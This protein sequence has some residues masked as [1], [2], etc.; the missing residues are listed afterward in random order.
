MDTSDLHALAHLLRSQRLAALGTLRSGGPSVSLA[1]YACA[2]DFSAFFF[3]F[4]RLALHTQDLLADPR[5]GLM[6]AEADSGAQNP[7]TLGRL[8][9]H[10]QAR[11]LGLDAPGYATAKGIYLAR[12]PFAEFNFS[13]NDFMM[14]HF[15]PSLQAGRYVAGFGKIFDVSLDDLRQAAKLDAGEERQRSD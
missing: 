15:T 10:G 1:L 4:S 2:P 12:F 13:L 7:L 9:L 6:I 14:F 3:H 8:S 11:A 5:A